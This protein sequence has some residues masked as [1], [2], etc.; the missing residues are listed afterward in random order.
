MA[1]SPFMDMLSNTSHLHSIILTMTDIFQAF[2]GNKP[3]DNAPVF[4]KAAYGVSGKGDERDM[5]HLLQVLRESY[6]DP[7]SDEETRAKQLAE[8]EEAV[9]ILTDFI[10]WHFRDTSFRTPVGRM[11]SWWYL[12]S[13]RVLVTKM[14][15]LS[16]KRGEKT[17]T[18]NGAEGSE[19]GRAKTVTVEAIMTEA[20]KQSIQFLKDVVAMIKSK[21]T[22][23]EGY[24]EALR[25]FKAWGIPVMPT[26]DVVQMFEDWLKSIPGVL[27]ELKKLG[28][29][30]LNSQHQSYVERRARRP[31]WVNWLIKQ[32]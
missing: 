20:G 16:V 11:V 24:E 32:L 18:I 8:G 31:S 12:N 13:W 3:S 6:I 22:R 28:Y 4:A 19:K 21:P 10:E 14:S 2:K 23:E 25:Y 5:Q 9:V 26:P 15:S 7:T 17:T 30:F 1:R 27:E 29:D